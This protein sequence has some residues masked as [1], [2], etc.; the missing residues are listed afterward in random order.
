MY[1]SSIHMYLFLSLVCSPLSLSSLCQSKSTFISFNPV[2]F[3]TIYSLSIHLYL[4]LSI[5]Y[6]PLFI[7][8]SLSIQIDAYL[9]YPHFHYLSLTLIYPPVS[10]SIFCLSTAISVCLLFIQIYIHLS[11]NPNSRIYLS[12]FF[13]LSQSIPHLFTSITFYLLYIS[14]A[15]QV[16]AYYSLFRFVYL[17]LSFVYPFVSVPIPSLFTAISLYFFVNPNPR[18]PL[19][20]P[21]YLSQSILCVSIYIYFYLLSIHLYLFISLCQ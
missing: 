16:R 12:M 15:I 10:I 7:Y 6:P 8:I 14:L 5:V 17:I 2:F 3:I 19:L 9:F 13:S 4:F 21:F 20:I 18:L 11:S 1:P